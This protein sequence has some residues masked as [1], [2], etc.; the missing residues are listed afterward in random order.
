[1]APAKVGAA[2]LEPSRNRGMHGYAADLP[3]MRSTFLILGPGIKPGHALGSIDMRD[4]A[5]T[6]AHVLGIALPQAEGKSLL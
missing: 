3:E 2:L 1:M 6:L 5:P 4:I